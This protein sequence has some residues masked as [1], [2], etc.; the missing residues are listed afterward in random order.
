MKFPFKRPA[1]ARAAPGAETARASERQGG[2]KSRFAALKERFAQGGTPWLLL[3]W[4]VSGMDAVVVQDGADTA[5]VLASAHSSEGRFP[6]ALNEVLQ[7]LAGQGYGKL[8]RVALAA[9]HLLPAVVDLP[10][11][12]DKPRRPEQMREL[13]QADLEP[14]LAEFGSVW[15]MGAL[16]QARGYLSATDRERV[17]MEESLRRQSRHNPLRYGEIAIELGLLTREGLDE[18]LDQQ[19]ALQNLDATLM[20]GWRGRSEDKQALW[21]A[22]GVGCNTYGEWREALAGHGLRLCA[23]LPLAW[24]VSDPAPEAPPASDARREQGV[25]VIALELHRE[26]V[27]AVQ[28]RHGQVVAARSEGRSERAPGADWLNRIVADWTAEPRA[29]IEIFF[30]N[31]EDDAHAEA[32][33]DT[34]HLTTGHPCTAHPSAAVRAGL[35]HK[36]LREAGAPRAQSRL[37]RLVDGELRGELW[38]NP[39]FRRVLALALVVLGLVGVES[40]QRY[41]L[42]GLEAKIDARQQ[43]EKQRQ[44]STQQEARVNRE[45]AELAR[46]LD[47]SRRKLEPLLNDR[48]RLNRI[49]SMRA[50][51]PDLL[52]LL[53]QSV[54]SDAVLEEIHNDNARSDGSAIQVAAWSPNYTGAQDFVSR[55]ANLVRGRGYGVS[56]MEIKERRGRNGKP[57]HQVGF[58]L[59]LEEHELEDEATPAAPTATPGSPPAPAAGAGVSSRAPAAATEAGR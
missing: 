36:L 10:V 33:C 50:D 55:V 49:M 20:A 51:L 56:Q 42:H 39:D 7:T 9:R 52:Y 57:G 29:R 35:W 53:A 23:T 48:S 13:I 46:E 44:F 18:C 27:V 59:V 16:M 4:D 25:P 24:L 41:R 11:A 45:L 14:A 3:T 19:A 58:W 32:L 8:R 1:A 30:L 22:C 21:L 34:L 31:E 43:Q 2:E 28:R 15:T 40:F 12:P 47:E 17:G 26:E 37:P 6:A 38:T 54:G 5:A